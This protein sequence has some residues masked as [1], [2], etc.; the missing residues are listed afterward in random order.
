M[1]TQPRVLIADALSPAAVSI[2]KERGVAADVKVGL[3]KEELEK[4]IGD[5]DGLAIRSAT[6]VTEK[7]I[8][9]AKKLRV[10]GRAGIGVDNVDVK[11]ATA[12]GVIVMNTPFGNSITT[13][14]H[15]ITMMMALARQIP[16]ADRSTQAG[17]WE[18]SKFLGVELYAK[19]LGVIGC[20][21]IGGIVADRGVGLKMKVIAYDPFLTPER[22]MQIGVEKVE[23]VDLFARADFITL[24]T[25]LT[26]R[27]KGIISAA[28]LARMKKGVRIINCARGGLI[29]EAALLDALKSG[30]VAG[31]ALDVFE[32]E[33][34]KENPLFG[35]PN[36]ICT[37]HLGAATNEA[38]ENVALQVA[39]QMSDY[40][41]KGAIS[42]AV[43]FPS[44]TAE[45]A[46]RLT[47][48]IKLAEQLGLFAGQLT[49]TN[50]KGIKISYS[51]AVAQLNTKPLTAAAVASVLK[52]LLADSIN[53]VSAAAVAKERGIQVEETTKGQDGTYESYI[54]LTVV[55]EKFE[56]SV[57]G[58]V[59]SDGRPR[60]IQ[61]RD[62]NMEFEVTPHMLFVRNSDK[63]GFIGKF[64]MVMGE[65]GVNIATLNLGRDKPGGDAICLVST[66]EAV[67]ESVLAKVKALPMVLRVNRLQF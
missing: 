40:L 13:A 45:E 32:V 50:I 38:Q 18:K 55:A 1:T 59:F 24:H 16:E 12:K 29:D 37:P 5:Y 62:I 3:S 43:N 56:R 52:P 39:E 15:A 47:P 42:N 22:A 63:P 8:A 11:A 36:L 51:G 46:P 58:T 28:S 30:Q 41:L 54:K 2:F 35:A 19:T 14:E 23:L 26:D 60:I 17:K 33:P 67:A 27:T 53:M 34:A 66:D 21:N 7:V 31:A 10:V 57:A 6:K 25:P 4:I 49:D 61:V 48:Y 20:G 65:A 9:A 44:I 64:G